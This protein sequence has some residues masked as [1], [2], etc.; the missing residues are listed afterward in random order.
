MGFKSVFLVSA[1]PHIFSNGYQI[2]FSEVPAQKCGIG[3]IVPEWIEKKL[4]VSDLQNIYGSDKVLPSTTIILPLKPEKVEAVKKELSEI[5]PEVLLFLLKIKK[6]SVREHNGGSSSTDSVSAVSITSETNPV[7]LRSQEADS[8]L[9]HLSYDQVSGAAS[10]CYYLQKQVFPV[11]AENVV[12]SRKDIKEWV[13]SI[14]F[15]FGERLNRGGTSTVGIFAFLPTSM[16]TNFPFIVQADFI[17]ASSRETI[18]LDNKWNMGILDYVPRTFVSALIT[19]MK[20]TETAEFFS[21][22]QVLNFLP[23]KASPYKELNGGE[24]DNQNYVNEEAYCTVRVIP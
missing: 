19:C 16:V 9:V 21:V 2:R 10:C 15:P 24:G 8:R 1:W 7:P 11:K 17:L 18:S 20:S 12:S 14:A 23:V 22:A 13:I 6:L 5:H 4:S 3:Y